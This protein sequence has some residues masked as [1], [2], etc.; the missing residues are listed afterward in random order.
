[1]LRIARLRNPRAIFRHY[2][3]RERQKS[4][5]IDHTRNLHHRRFDALS[6]LSP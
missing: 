6:N 2:N 1:M 4:D 3:H 5:L